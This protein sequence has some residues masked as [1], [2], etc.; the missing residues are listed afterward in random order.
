MAE[1]CCGSCFCF[2]DVKRAVVAIGMLTGVCSL[3]Q[4]FTTIAVFTGMQQVNVSGNSDD[5]ITYRLYIALACFDFVMVVVSFL[6]VY[7]SE[8]S[9]GLSRCY[10]LPWVILLPF[11]FIYETAVNI[12][13]FYHQ[14][15][16]GSGYQGPL[17]GGASLGFAVVPLVY[18][19][20]KAILL[21]TSWVYLLVRLQHIN[22]NASPKVK[23][24]RQVESFHEYDSA[25]SFPHPS[26]MISLPPAP[27]I[28]KPSQYCHPAP[29]MSMPAAPSFPKSS[30]IQ[31]TSCSG[32]CSADRCNKCNLP[33][34]MYGY[35]GQQMGNTGYAGQQMGNTGSTPGAVQTKGWTTS[36]YNAG[37]RC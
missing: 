15:T 8:V 2:R 16:A 5:E 27:S 11:Y 17:W 12:Y 32:G 10:T 18:W 23:Y 19:I 31:C 6:L 29:M 28:P 4:I 26:P 14:F 21:F 33:Q 3:I 20:T 35:A 37:G 34:P 7:G 1:P 22:L 25:P 9:A 13:Y 36:I 30:S 24:V